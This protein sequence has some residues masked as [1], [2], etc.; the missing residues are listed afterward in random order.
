[1]IA[2]GDHEVKGSFEEISGRILFR[3]T[4]N[5]SKKAVLADRGDLLDVDGVLWIVL[6]PG[7]PVYKGVEHNPCKISDDELALIVDTRIVRDAIRSVQDIIGNGGFNWGR[8]LLIGGIIALVYYL[9]QTGW[10]PDFLGDLIP[11][12]AQTTSNT[13]VYEVPH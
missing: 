1:M 4:V 10:L 8:W 2:Y 6:E 11:H 9:W 5:G 12:A 7:S 3:F 13:T